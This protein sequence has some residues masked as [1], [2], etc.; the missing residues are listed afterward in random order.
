MAGSSALRLA[1]FDCD[2]TLVDSQHMIARC[3]HAAFDSEGLT[4]PGVAAVRRVVG[5]PL[6]DC[7]AILAPERD[8]AG[9]VRLAEAFRHFF[10]LPSPDAAHQEPLFAGCRETLAALEAEG[11][12]LGIATAKGRRG[13]DGVLERHGLVGRFVTLQTGDTTPGKPHPAVLGRAL[14]E[15][16]VDAAD[17]VMIGDTSYDMAMARQ[18]GVRPIGV[19]WGYHDPAELNAAG[20]DAVADDYAHLRRLLFAMRAP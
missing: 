5:L 11:W 20:A 4:P 1:I 19:A 7:M 3:M 8:A 2:G 16:G 6:V 12:L 10:H 18:A 13:L 14:A 17:A 15:A 9:H